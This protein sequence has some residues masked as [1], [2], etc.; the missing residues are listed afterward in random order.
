MPRRLEIDRILVIGSG[1]VR[2]GQAAE[3]DYSGTQACMSFREEGIYVVLLNPNPASIQT[4]DDIADRIYIEPVT[5][6]TVTEIISRE[7][8]H[9]IYASVGGQTALNIVVLLKKLGVLDS[10]NVEVLGTP[11]EAIETAEDRSRFSELVEKTGCQIARSVTISSLGDIEN[12]DAGMIPCIART[13]FSLGGYGGR[14]IGSIEELREYY[15]E[16]SMS[17]GGAKI[18]IQKSLE[19]M[20]EF[21]YELIR[22][23]LGNRIAVCNMENIDPMGVHTG[24]SIV[25]T[26]SQTIDDRTHQRMRDSGFRIID[27][28]GIVGACNI[29]FALDENSDIYAVEV[30]PRT[31]RSSALASKASGYPISRIASKIVLGYSLSEIR[32]PITG[33][34]FASFEPSL[35]YITVKIPRWPFDKFN[36]SRTIGVQ[37]KSVGEVMGIGRTFEEALMKAIASLETSDGTR[38][39]TFLEGDKLRESLIHP[40]DIRLFSIFEALFQGMP[41]ERISELT[42]I[43]Q[44]FIKKI[45]NVISQLRQLKIGS[46]PDNLDE[47]KRLGISDAQISFFTG[48]TETQIVKHRI[49]EKILPCYRAIDTCSG[50]FRSSTPYYY[51][52]YGE[53]GEFKVSGEKTVLIVGAGPN[54]IGQGVEFD[55]VAVKGI[56]TLRARGF[57]AVMINSNPETVSTDFD[58]SSALFFEPVTL[59][60]TANLVALINPIGVIVQFS[61][62]TGQNMASGLS[63]LFGEDIILGTKPSEIFNIE[64]RNRFASVLKE[65]GIL[66]PEF[67]SVSNIQD[68]SDATASLEPPYIMRSSFIIGGRAMEIFYDRKQASDRF[69]DILR[70]RP[71]YS[72]LVS[73]YIENALEIDID[74]VANGR[75]YEI[76]GIMPH[77]EEAGTHSGDATMILSPEVDTDLEKG[78]RDM[79]GKI[80]A[81]FS[82]SGLCNLQIAVR[83]KDIYVIELNARASRSIPFLCKATGKDWV[84]QA[85]DVMLGSHISVRSTKVRSYFLKIPVFPFDRY[86]DLEPL[87]GPEMKSTGEAMVSGFS[88]Q[89]AASKASI[90]MGIKK[91]VGG[92]IISVKDR[93]KHEIL[94]LAR[95]LKSSGVTI[96]ATPGTHIFLSENGIDSELIYKMEDMRNPRIDRIIIER[97]VSMVIN[98]PSSSSGSMRDG[99]RVRRLCLQAGIPLITN[100]KLASMIVETLASRPK[101]T[102]RSIAEYR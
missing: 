49:T 89:E 7:K 23:S 18:E 74:F 73:R 39:R 46:I 31:S 36:V 91:I 21:E 33:N 5:A 78:I 32:N 47:I 100:V 22:D 6:E 75:S 95:L 90:I 2:I 13:S 38:L 82:L 45:E 79:L 71:G 94:G 76:C 34:T 70:E 99:F 65:N 56:K 63:E 54:R 80:T 83:G 35:D 88:M 24:E 52:T 84:S 57:Q 4:D 86:E 43:D 53:S 61:G 37:M 26:P 68:F 59:E 50:E 15:R 11:I 16:I 44:Y 9:F 27:A 20:K 93:D 12:I 48:I 41:V 92:A 85:V 87:L 28:L 69:M 98:T 55:Y 51:S 25:V 72:V 10:M 42:R 62:Q 102:A 60:H 30:N 101:L 8:I 3:F 17:E 67:R 40:S 19:G 1:P 81:A 58:I 97:R 66:Q 14:M 29:Q 64:E 77:I 96:F